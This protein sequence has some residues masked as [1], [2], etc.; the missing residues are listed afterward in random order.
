M[1]HDPRLIR[2]ARR[3]RRELS[4]AEKILWAR[5]RGRRFAG[6]RFRRQHLIDPYIADFCCAVAALVIELDGETHL[7]KEEADRTRQTYLESTGLKVLRFWN[8]DVFEGLD[9]VLEAVYRECQQR[10]QI[11]PRPQPSR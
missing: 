4:S 10:S 7:G 3:L 9:G 8:T 11:P 5:L 2:N 1:Y 6:Y